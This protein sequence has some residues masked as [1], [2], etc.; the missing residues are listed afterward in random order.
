MILRET[1]ELFDDAE[2]VSNEYDADVIIYSGRIDDNGLSEII[3]IVA[4]A[5][6]R[7]NCL[8]ILTT[9]GG[10]P[11]SGYQI[12]RLLQ[13][14]YKKFILYSPGANKSAGTLIA[15]GAHTLVMD[16]FSELGPLDIQG[17]S[18]EDIMGQRSG[19][20]SR[21]ALENLNELSYELFE[22]ILVRMKIRF[23]EKFSFR[24]ASDIATTLTSQMFS[25]IY[26]QI[27]PEVLG[28]DFRDLNVGTEYGARLA[29][30]SQ[31]PLPTTVTKLVRKYP[32]H[33]F[34]IDE[35]EAK[36]L[37]RSVQ[38]PTETLYALIKHLSEIVYSEQKTLFVKRLRRPAPTST[39]DTTNEAPQNASSDSTDINAPGPVDG[40]RSR[41]QSGNSS[42]SG[43]HGKSAERPSP[44][45]SGRSAGNEP[46]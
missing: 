2:A 4:D 40:D 24:L 8:L 31:N 25:S 16:I 21:A 15:L 35:D 26:G 37:F 23:G 3:G 41:D 32:S 22:H 1:D 17:P 33:D 27:S 7:P 10:L 30:Y 44:R 14:S 43:R 39:E 38:A 6:R 42:Q 36:T 29:K 46:A 9:N 28:T 20:I 11:N 45:K 5:P 18:G 34:I 19:L 13:K 12:A